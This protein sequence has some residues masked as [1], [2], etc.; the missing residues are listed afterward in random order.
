[1]HQFPVLG[2]V[3]QH[4]RVSAH[5]LVDSNL[6]VSQVKEL[7][8]GRLRLTLLLAFQCD[9]RSRTGDVALA[10]FLAELSLGRQKPDPGH[11][12]HQSPFVGVKAD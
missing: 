10:G 7:L 8:A 11:L 1:M 9:P 2:T 5:A 4:P 3:P 12:V 6:S